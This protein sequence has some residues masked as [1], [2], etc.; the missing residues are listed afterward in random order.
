MKLLQVLTSLTEEVTPVFIVC[1]ITEEVTPGT[2]I[3][4]TDIVID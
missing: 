3:F 2:A 1:E 4:A